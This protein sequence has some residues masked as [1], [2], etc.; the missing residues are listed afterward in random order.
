MKESEIRL[1]AGKCEEVSQVLKSLSH[2]VRLKV[3]CALIDR[4]KTVGELVEFGG[5]SQSAMSQFLIRLRSEGVLQ[6][7]K[8]GTSVYY[9]LSDPKLKKLIHAIKEV[10]CE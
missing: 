1:M 4:E 5:I 7:R 6:S 3:L 10:F 8:E 2:P 9:T